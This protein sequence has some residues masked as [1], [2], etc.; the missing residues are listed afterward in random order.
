MQVI[1]FIAALFFTSCLQ[2]QN[3]NVLSLLFRL[4]NK[5]AFIPASID[6]IVLLNEN[7]TEAKSITNARLHNNTYVMDSVKVGKYTLKISS[8]TLFVYPKPVVVCSRCENTFVL[9]VY[10]KKESEEGVFTMVEVMPSYAGSVK[11]LRNDFRNSLSKRER[12]K[13]KR[14]KED[15]ILYFFITKEKVISDLH[16]SKNISADV[17][18]I[19]L[20]GLSALKNWSPAILNGIVIDEKY[21]LKS[22]LLF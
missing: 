21:S 19:F 12:K 9:E 22:S 16:F 5:A 2:A 1:L 6:T 4:E 7:K 8:P 14:S 17:K 18:A 10:P 15:F 20:K 11:D 13:V 3:Q